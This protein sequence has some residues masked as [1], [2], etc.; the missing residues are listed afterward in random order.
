M[1]PLPPTTK[2]LSR[3]QLLELRERA[4]VEGRCV[5]QCHGCFDIVHPGHIRHL[6]HA[7]QQ[8]DILL[9]SITADSVMNKGDGRPLFPQDLR[10]ENLAALDFVDWVFINPDA[11]AVRLLDQVQPDVYIKGREYESNNDPRFAAERDAVER[12]GGSV[13]FSSGDIVFSSTALVRAMESEHDPFHAR[14]HQLRA[15]GALDER[16][17]DAT[18]D[19]FAGM[20]CVVV[21]EVIV[22]TYVHCDQPVVASESPV[23][24][25]RPLERVSDDGGG[26]IIARHMAAM[27]AHPTLITAL[28][29]TPEAQAI[30]DR[31][32]SEGVRVLD[33]PCEGSVL[34]KQR[35]LVGTQKMMKLDIVHPIALDSSARADIV[36]LARVSASDAEAAI[37]ADFGNGLVSGALLDR[38]IDAVRPSVRTLAGDVSG[39]RAALAKMRRMDLLCPTEQELRTALGDFDSSLNAVVASFA[40]RTGV[41]AVCVTL[42]AE[43]LIAFERLEAPD[44]NADG[45]RTVVTGEHIPAFTH[46]ALDTLGCGDALLAA[47]TLA[48]ASGDTHQ[49]AACLGAI[50]AASEA[51][52]LGNRPISAGDLRRGIRAVTGARLAISPVRSGVSAIG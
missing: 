45:S 9:V 35:F 7:A 13:V 43:G 39:R 30:K 22:D 17:L 25:L 26:A 29:R 49:R 1:S 36:E 20:R 14:L 16:A 5:V 27:G 19:R 8:G 51:T 37:I 28:P 24:S 42:G 18:I 32:E 11:T 23:L 41:R 47:T 50:A 34:E 33:V 4:R 44:Q 21:G 52:R 38:L 6:R 48:L 10:A 31:L 12:H 40:E 15:S 46:H 2:I 3:R